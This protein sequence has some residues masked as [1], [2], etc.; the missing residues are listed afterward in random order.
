[1]FRD[2]VALAIPSVVANITTPL[3]SMTDIAIMGHLGSA[4]YIAAIAVGGTM[5][6]LLYWLLGFLR[7]A[8][9]GLTA[10]ASGR[11]DTDEQWSVITRSLLI[12]ISIGVLFIIF[13]DSLG[14]LL[15][16]FIDPD[17][18]TESLA[19]QYFD[20]CIWGAP[21]TLSMYVFTGWFIGMQSTKQAMWVS[22]F[23]NVI[24]IPL[25]IILVYGFDMGIRGAA[26]GTL[27]AQWSGILLAVIITVVR[28]HP[29]W[30][31]WE[32]ILRRN[33]IGH[34]FKINT[35]LFLRTL[36]M[37]AVTLWFTRV[38]AMQGA[39][40]LAANALL[41]QL[42]TLF[43]YFMDGFA[44]AGEALCGRYKGAGDNNALNDAIKAVVSC[45]GVLALIF[46]IVYTLAGQEI[47]ALLSNDMDVLKGSGE[48]LWWAV[49]VPIAGF[50][51]FAWDGIVTGTSDTRLM[52]LS[53]GVASIAFFILW[54]TVFPVYGNHALWFAFIVYLLVRG[55]VLSA[56][57]RCKHRNLS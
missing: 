35:D 31:G 7:M 41:M 55:I 23:I 40:V 6:N 33:S 36:C 9:S 16:R 56:A 24:N 1:M 46:S 27:A 11:N 26:F 20:I 30:T 10:Q 44:F 54:W 49:T 12:A 37:V 25:S 39:V 45:G 42:F 19:A 22:V 18:A 21:A 48:Y 2:V 3:L 5:F 50:T 57:Y 17:P 28:F 15:L 47:L 4:D 13:S 51:A 14:N 34:L 43:S 8:T 38:G 32:K 52:L 53:T 29:K